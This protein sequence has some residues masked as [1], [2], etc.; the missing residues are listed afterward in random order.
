MHEFSRAPS[1]GSAMMTPK[2]R[3]YPLPPGVVVAALVGA[4]LMVGVGCS[5]GSSSN[6][7]GVGT[8]DSMTGDA[9]ASDTAFDAAGLDSADDWADGN[10]A[11]ADDVADSNGPEVGGP[12]FACASNADCDSNTC[13]DTP[14][15]RVCAQKCI[16]ECPSAFE[17]KQLPGADAS[18]YCLP[19]WLHTCEPCSTSTACE[20]PGF[21][22]AACIDRGDAGHFCGTACDDSGDCPTGYACALVNSVEGTESQQCL[23]KAG[24][25]CKCSPRAAKLK[26]TT[27]CKTELDTGAC[28]GQRGCGLSTEATQTGQLSACDAKPAAEACNGVDDDC[29]GQTDEAL[30][31]DGNIC[32]TDVCDPGL[33][34]ADGCTHTAAPGGCDADANACTE[35]D[36]CKAGACMAGPIK[37]CDDTNPCTLD[38]CLPATGCTQTLDDGKACSDDDACTLGDVCLGGSC[39]SG[40]QKTCIPGGFCV[41]AACDKT[42][43]AC[44]EKPRPAGTPCADDNACTSNDTCDGATCVGKTVLCDDKNTCTVDSCHP[45]LGCQSKASPQPCDDGSACTAADVCSAGLCVG[46][47]VDPKV[48]C[49]DG[50]PCTT[51]TCDPKGAAGTPKP[52]CNHAPNQQPCDDGNA[53]TAGDL[54]AVGACNPGT[55]TCQCTVDSDCA[56]KED[57]D[58]CNGTLYCDKGAVPYK[59][60]VNPQ[61]PVTCSKAGDSACQRAKCAPKTGQCSQQPANEG[62]PC[63]ADGSVCTVGD[64]CLGGACK[65]GN[66]I[67]CDDSNPCTVDACDAKTGC[68]ATTVADKTACG[69]NEWCVAGSCVASVWCGDGKVNLGG[70]QCDDGNNNDGD[71]CSATCKKEAAVPPTVASLVISEVM[72]DPDTTEKYGEWFEVHNPGTVGI[73]LTGIEIGDGFG[74][75]TVKT[76]GLVIDAGGYFVFAN[77]A[78]LGGGGKAGYVYDYTKSGIAFSNKGDSV[79]VRYQGQVIDTVTYGGKGW[80][81][82]PSGKSYQLSANALTAQKNNAAAAWCVST[83]PFGTQNAKGTPGTKNALCP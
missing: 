75:E 13:I 20:A 21:S 65:P 62:Q 40:A 78:T 74:K 69:T 12:G 44:V 30:C 48:W 43:G 5:D 70:E 46:K 71:G 81:P 3:T 61:T 66:T 26:L 49:D 77:S 80:P 63:D 73:K 10:D 57:G 53:C 29:D 55:N 33:Q 60:A 64:V 56:S 34:L 16:D 23:P 54:C 50:N 18:F 59:C 22:G 27:A 58:L 17:C 11:T 35:G 37:S 14:N 76:A 8:A 38:A 28:F 19:R 25:T 79:I 68:A 42:T 15:G 45:T 4:A 51:D 39:S 2:A 24:A 47:P 7:T 36:A 31:G 52:G 72:A 6:G 83:A 9:S 32:T 67:K 1:T 82:V 41:T